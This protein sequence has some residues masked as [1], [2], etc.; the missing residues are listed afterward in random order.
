MS[1][2]RVDPAIFLLLRLQARG[3]RRRMWQRFCQPRRIVLSA[4]AGV[5]AILWLGNA[6]MTVWL[7]EAAVAN[8]L[9]AL[10]S[11]GLLFYAT[12]HFAKAAFFR[13]E[14][15]FEW[16]PADRDVL[17]VLPWHSRDLVAYQIASVTVTTTLKT[18]LLTLLL[19]PDLRCIPLAAVGLLLAMLALEL[20]RMAVDIATW[21]MSRAAFL[22]YRITV[23]AGLV[24]GGFVI[25]TIVYREAI[26]AGQINVG[27][28]LL[29]RF[30]EILLQLN[31]TAFSFVALPFRP[32][33]DLIV[34][35]SVTVLRLILAA[36]ALGGVLLFAAGVIVLYGVTARRVAGREKRTYSVVFT[37]RVK[38]PCL[39]SKDRPSQ[40]EAHANSAKSQCSS[41][42][43]PR[44]GGAGALAWRQ[45]IGARRSWGS[46]LTA[47]IA[48]AVLAC[49]PCFVIEDA[50]IAL[51]AT[52]GTLAFYTFLL[53]PT[54]VR[55]DFRRDL[56]R[57]AL[58]KGLPISPAATVIGQTVTP[59]L[60]ATAF[61]SAV[62][63]FAIV[64]RSLSPYYFV[65][66]MLVMLPLNALVFTLDNLIYLLYPYRLQ[67]EGVEIFVRTMLTFTGKGLLFALGL[68]AMS[69]WGFGAA[70]L[71]RAVS[72][73]T[74]IAIDPFAVFTAGMI[75][76]PAAMAA[77]VLYTLAQT[78][79]RMDVI[80]DMPR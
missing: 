2:F 41:Q 38:D 70:L 69:G 45:L 54:A 74:A 53:L 22:A 39:V 36:A 7:R 3:R 73:W 24:V 27:E 13:P 29:D 63:A 15:P 8:T 17:A 44:L 25:G 60:V 14:S 46:L 23:V 1:T 51:L 35:D 9:S 67:Q 61:Q 71:T 77:L 75:A 37:L 64:A 68:A 18:G 4:V 79:H 32:F 30:L 26:R 59:V 11:L 34:A 43:I 48:P 62:L 49:A 28:G 56:D 31:A 66:S 5:L 76:G 6:A 65:S 42:R 78:Y 12:W 80:E 57:M 72:H 52:A 10:V 40:S 58:L 16:C 55:F 20:L 19:L 47:M 50:H 33:V 21:G